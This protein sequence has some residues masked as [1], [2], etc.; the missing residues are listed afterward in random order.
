M[1]PVISRTLRKEYRL[2]AP[3]EN[4]R[5]SLSFIGVEPDLP[6]SSLESLEIPIALRDGFLIARMPGGAIIEGTP[7]HFISAFHGLTFTDVVDGDRGAPLIHGASVLIGGKRLL[8]VGKKGCG[9]STLALHLAL[10]GH[11]V[12][13]DEHLLVRSNEVIAR[14]RTLRVKESSMALIADAPK[15]VWAAPS[16]YN[17]DGSTIQAITPSFGGRPWVIR[18]GLLSAIV[19]LSANY[20]G[21]SVACPV[22]PSEALARLMEEIMLP[23]SGVAAAAGRIQRL[24]RGVPSYELML[25]E[26]KSAEWHLSNIAGMSD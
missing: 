7:N 11:C 3:T 8:L 26:L 6:D 22:A 19:F 24:S 17:W 2:Y 15:E 12:E 20:G 14:P 4:I 9:K 10:A 16:I 1:R 5:E 18:S 23:G 21:R 25:G 13:G